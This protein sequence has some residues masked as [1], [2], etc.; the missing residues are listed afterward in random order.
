MLENALSGIKAGHGEVAFLWGIHTKCE[1]GLHCHTQSV[2]ASRL[3]AR[4]RELG[5]RIITVC[6][7]PAYEQIY[8]R[9]LGLTQGYFPA[10]YRTMENLHKGKE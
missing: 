5:A 1:Y 10:V 7:E 2:E 6:K 4:A 8:R 9:V 3:N